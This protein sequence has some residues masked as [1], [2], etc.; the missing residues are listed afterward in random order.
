MLSSVLAMLWSLQPRA[1]K[2]LNTMHR[3]LLSVSNYYSINQCGE[4]PKQHKPVR[5]A[6]V[7]RASDLDDL[8]DGAEVRFANT[9][10]RLSDTLEAC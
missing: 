8:T 5:S 7:S 9:P 1:F 4:E 6:G 10:K 2:S 3:S